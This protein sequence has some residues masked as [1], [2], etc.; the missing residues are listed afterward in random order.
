MEKLTRRDLL[1]GSALTTAALSTAILKPDLELEAPPPDTRPAVTGYYQAVIPDTLDLP[2]RARLGINALISEIS[3]KFDYECWWLIYVLPPGVEPHSNQWF[4]QNPRTLWTL[5]LFRTM[6]GSDYGLEIEEKMKDSMLSRTTEDGLYLNAPFDTPGAWWRSGGAGGRKKWSTKE[7]FTNPSGMATLLN[8]MIARYLK[9]D[10]R[11]MLERGQRVANALSRIVIRKN[12]YAYYPAT[13]NFGAEYSYMKNSGWPDTKEAISDQDDPEGSVS[14]YQAFVIGPLA[15]WHA[16]TGDPKALETAGQ[17]VRYVLKPRFWTGGESPWTV[18]GASQTHSARDLRAGHGGVERKPAALFQGHQAGMTYTFAGL[19]DYALVANDAYVKEW[20]RQGYEY[21]RN[22]GLPQIGMWGEN[23]ANNMMAEIAI[24]LSDAGAGDYWDDVDHYVRNCFVEDQFVGLELLKQEAKK[25]DL[26]TRQ[27]SQYGDFTTEQFI[28]CL[29]HVGLVDQQGTLDPTCNVGEGSTRVLDH[30][31]YMGSA[32][33]AHSATTGPP[34]T[35]LFGSC[36]LEPFYFVWEAITRFRG[37]VAQVN[38][39]LNRA[40]AWL[41][42]D[43]H[44]PY[45]GKVVLKNKAC[46]GIHV[47][48]PRWADRRA[49]TCRNAAGDLP[50]SWAGNFLVLSGLMGKEAITLEFPMTESVETYYLLGPDV[51]P[52]WWEHTGELPTYVVYMRGS[53]C[54]KVEFPNRARFTQLPQMYPVF[55][56]EHFG[57]NEAPMKTVTRYVHPRVVGW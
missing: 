12:D 2:E 18:V 52:K 13:T 36:Y 49:I 44:L 6:T 10:D 31:V 56:R 28:G 40:S 34:R 14:C 45:S 42:I 8:A 3:P 48:I 5:A 1:S 43:S 38:L 39:L 24:K 46:T 27:S 37:G 33:P 57:A 19:A 16:V 7:D 22:L 55:Q 54:I 30:A 21:F 4:D 23:I 26:P 47:R 25:H 32:G 20:V 51:G 50:F 11:S 9:D 29:R 41:D 15:R 17:L 35:G 53:T